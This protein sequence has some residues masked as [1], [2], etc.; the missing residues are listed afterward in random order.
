[1]T[2]GTTWDVAAAATRSVVDLVTTAVLTIAGPGDP[3]RGSATGWPVR[4]NRPTSPEPP[5]TGTTS[6]PPAP[7][8]GSWLPR[9][10]RGIVRT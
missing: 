8:P 1:M 10:A 6:P 9:V 7:T 4:V 5:M 2:R 3:R